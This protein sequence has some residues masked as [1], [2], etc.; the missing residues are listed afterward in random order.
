MKK[1]IGTNPVLYPMPVLIIGTYDK[2]GRPNVMNASWGGICCAEP[3]CVAVAVRKTRYTYE[4]ITERKAF[5]IGVPTTEYVK[6]VDY[7]GIKSG[8]DTEKLKDTGLTPLKS[9]IVD[10][11]Y[12]EEFPVVLE[13]SLKE[14]IDIG[15]HVQI[16]GEIMD[17][18]VDEDV[19]DDKDKP[20][21]KKIDPLIYVPAVRFYYDIGKKMA[22]AFNIGTKI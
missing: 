20:D 18:K 22:S 13:C 2:D 5:T 8:R 17:I 15:S 19:L 21:V 4:N 1:S 3:P 16:I 14:H 7:F 9:D 12:V 10:A 6:E 11:P